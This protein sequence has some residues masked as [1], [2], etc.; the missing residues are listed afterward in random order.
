MSEDCFNENKF[1]NFDPMDK[2]KNILMEKQI[3]YNDTRYIDAEVNRKGDVYCG[4]CKWYKE[5]YEDDR[6]WDQC[7]NEATAK[8]TK[9]PVK[10][11]IHLAD[12]IHVNANNNCKFFEPDEEDFR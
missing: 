12:P 3:N 8:I 5:I 9:T 2:K 4:E 7:T 10:R 11:I 6:G 1:S